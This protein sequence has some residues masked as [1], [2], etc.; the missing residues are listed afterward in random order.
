MSYGNCNRSSHLSRKRHESAMNRVRGRGVK[1]GSAASCTHESQ[2]GR[3]HARSTSEI[4]L[5]AHCM[6]Y[7]PRQRGS[8]STS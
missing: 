6:A 5:V 1:N 2:E 8:F 3:S 4:Q 7:L